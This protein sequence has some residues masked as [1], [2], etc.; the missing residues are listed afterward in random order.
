LGNDGQVGLE[1]TTDG[2]SDIAEAL[3]DGGLELV[4]QG[5]ALDISSV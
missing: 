5:R 1:V 2:T 4:G 3:Q